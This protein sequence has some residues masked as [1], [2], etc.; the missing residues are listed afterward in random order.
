[1][2]VKDIRARDQQRVRDLRDKGYTVEIIWEKVWQ[3]LITQQPEIKVYLAQHRTYTHFKKYL[4][5]IKLFNI[6]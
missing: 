5:N 1:M 6:P 2:T 3:T 4:T